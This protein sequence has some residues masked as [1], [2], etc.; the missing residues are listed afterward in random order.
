[1]GGKHLARVR[2]RALYLKPT[3][4]NVLYVLL[5]NLI[6]MSKNQALKMPI[7]PMNKLIFVNKASYENNE[8]VDI[9]IVIGG[10]FDS[11]T[12]TF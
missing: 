1:M 4:L 7:L 10:R 5:M 9:L 8:Y 11:D 3:V 2:T 12:W 6:Y